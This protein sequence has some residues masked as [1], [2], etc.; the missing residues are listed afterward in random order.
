[1]G[2]WAFVLALAAQYAALWLAF[3]RINDVER[4]AREVKINLLATIRHVAK[5][6]KKLNE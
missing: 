4:L 6:Q 2:Q 1:M 3:R 5:I